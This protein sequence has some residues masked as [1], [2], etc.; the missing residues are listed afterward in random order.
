MSET[1][2][3]RVERLT[4]LSDDVVEVRL[5]D[6][7][8][9][10]LPGWEPGAHLTLDLPVGL[11][12]Q[13]SL[14]GPPTDR[15]GWTVAVHRAPDSR[16]GSAYVHDGVRIGALLPVGGPHQD[17][18]LEAGAENLLVAGGIGIT[19]ILAMARALA[20]AGADWSLLYC[21]RT[22]SALAYLDELAALD[23]DGSRV[24]VHLDDEAGGP[25]D[26]AAVLAGRPWATVHCCGPTSM[27]DAVLELAPD[28]GRVHVERFRAP[29]VAPSATAD[30]GFDVHCAASDVRVRVEPG[31]SVLAA[32]G[33]AGISV[34]SSCEEGICGTC[35]VKVLAGE[36]EHRD[37]VLTDD[38]RAAGGSMF[39]CVSRCRGPELVL[40]L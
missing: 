40:D 1:R 12:R 19:P 5:A 38:E 9:G 6:P 22:R 14:C 18:P 2:T 23:P 25:A 4:R 8:G 3:L 17:F 37:L 16:G 32:L 20:A 10:E 7:A 13:Y 35:E 34:P 29:E 39:V 36:P 21:G 30:T 24:R 33:G 28:P 15:T 26:L 11:T 27:I 31:C